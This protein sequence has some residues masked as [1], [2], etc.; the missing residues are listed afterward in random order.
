MHSVDRLMAV[1]FLLIIFGIFGAIVG[2]VELANRHEE[3]M[4]ELGYRLVG[5]CRCHRMWAKEPQVRVVTNYLYQVPP[6]EYVIATN[7]YACPPIEAVPLSAFGRDAK[8]DGTVS[9]KED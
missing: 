3:R 7:L 5:D 2:I 4:A 6:V 9:V 8:L 1:M